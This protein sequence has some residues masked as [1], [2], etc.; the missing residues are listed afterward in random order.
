[1]F[2]I[3]AKKRDSKEHGARDTNVSDNATARVRPGD[4]DNFP[5]IPEK[6]REVLKAKGY[7]TLFPI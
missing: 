3:E 1:M 2:I 4:F 7:R 6:S 5:L